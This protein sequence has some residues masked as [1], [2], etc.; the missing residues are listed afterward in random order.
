MTPDELNATFDRLALTLSTAADLLG[1]SRQATWY[2]TTGQ[3]PVPESIAR[4]LR[5]I[6]SVGVAKAS[7]AFGK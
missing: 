2:W 3:R 1:V 6:E 7:R 5:L 4:F